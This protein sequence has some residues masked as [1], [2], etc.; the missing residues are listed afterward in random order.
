MPLLH[1]TKQLAAAN[2]ACMLLS[3][4]MPSCQPVLLADGCKAP[5]KLPV[6]SKMHVFSLA[7]VRARGHLKGSAQQQ[8]ACAE[9]MSQC[10]TILGV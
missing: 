5:Y 10:M 6:Y 1:S 7:A 8:H 9:G 4:V 3:G 2:Q